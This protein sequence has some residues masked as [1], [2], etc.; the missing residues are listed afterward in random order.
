M[1][2]EEVELQ[3]LILGIYDA[4]IDQKKW[5]VVLD[6]VSCFVGARGAM[7]FRLEKTGAERRIIASYM[8]VVYE[9]YWLN[10]YFRHHQKQE[11]ADQDRWGDYCKRT[12]GIELI[13]DHVIADSPEEL[14]N[15]PNAIM[16]RKLGIHHRCGAFLN[17]D[18]MDRDRFSMQFSEQHGPLNADDARKMSII[19]PHIAKALNV[20]RPMVQLQE[21]FQLVLGYLDQLKVGVC[22]LNKD[23]LLMLK[24][25]EFQRQMEAYPV[26]RLSPSGKLL[27]N[28]PDTDGAVRRLMMNVGHHG[29]FGA[30]PRKEAVSALIDREEYRLCIEV[31]PLNKLDGLQA[32]PVSGHV[33]FSLD[34]RMPPPLNTPVIASLFDLTNTESEILSL[35]A[36]GL[37]NREISERRSKSVET[38]NT[39]TKSILAKTMTANRTQLIRLATNLS[40]NFV[41]A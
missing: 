20:S 21:Q 16:L 24:N 6:R 9:P 2:R 35:I 28:D 14:M 5:P 27:F 26:Y 41:C 22:F 29:H 4:A 19:L 18:D 38:V 37:T 17:K 34:T 8:S 33:V 23:G 39:Q 40:S 15:R 31:L 13:P 11:L 30:R 1:T 12:D 32:Q 3:D 25:L 7:F 10:E 36:E